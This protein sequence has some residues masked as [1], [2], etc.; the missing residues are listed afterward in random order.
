VAAITIVATITPVAAITIVATITPVA[1]VTTAAIARVATTTTSS[2][3]T[4]ITTT[5]ATTTDSKAH[6]TIGISGQN[7][8]RG[9]G[10]GTEDE[11]WNSTHIAYQTNEGTLDY[12]LDSYLNGLIR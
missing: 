6:V 4:L 3:T 2:M 10:D 11:N 9:H 12:M 8:A 1:A 7:A 5:A